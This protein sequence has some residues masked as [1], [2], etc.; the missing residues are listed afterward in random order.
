MALF[1]RRGDTPAEAPRERGEFPLPPRRAHCSVCAKE[2]SF[3]K[4]WRRNGMVRQCTCCGMVFENP[5]ALY[6]L[7]QP[8]C[9]KCEEPLE[10]PNFDYGLCDGCGSKFELIENTK[11]GLIPNLRQRRERD[12]HGKSRSVL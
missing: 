7:V 5:A 10:Q 4:S 8:V 1:G 3:T 9:P 12:S 6:N 11:P 2:Q